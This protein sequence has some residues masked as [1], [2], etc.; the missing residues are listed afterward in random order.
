MNC[1]FDSGSGHSA[2][3]VEPSKCIQVPEHQRSEHQRS[4]HQRSE[5]QRSEHQLKSAVPPA[6]RVHQ[7][8]VRHPPQLHRNHR[9][10][11]FIWTVRKET[12]LSQPRRQCKHRAN[13]G[14]LAAKAVERHRAKAV[15]Q[16]RR[17]RKHKRQ[18]Q[19]LSREGSGNTKGKGSILVAKAAQTQKAK[20]VS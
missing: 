17:Q 18:R 19:C 10:Q 11:N 8:A 14:V 12:G 9:V 5:H 4:E 13:G 1:P 3:T 2:T 7:P 6:R 16:P 20:A 15:S